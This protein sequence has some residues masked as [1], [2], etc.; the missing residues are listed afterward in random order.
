MSG[1]VTAQIVSI[2]EPGAATRTDV[3][4]FGLVDVFVLLQ[5]VFRG[6]RVFASLAFEGS[7]SGMCSF[8]AL[9]FHGLG[10]GFVAIA[11]FVGLFRAMSGPKNYIFSLIINSFCNA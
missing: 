1:F 4:F 3:R 2:S 9:Q 8:V 10:E 7:F 6:E 5:I 11:A